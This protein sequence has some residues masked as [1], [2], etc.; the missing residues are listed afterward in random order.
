MPTVSAVLSKF[1]RNDPPSGTDGVPLVEK[2]M[3]V[4]TATFSVSPNV[5]TNP[6]LVRVPVGLASASQLP[7]SVPEVLAATE[8]CVVL[9]P[10]LGAIVNRYGTATASASGAKAARATRAAMTARDAFPIRR[11]DVG[12]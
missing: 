1:M 2:L 5:P 7:M 9:R 8:A 3:E 6:G 11:A 10:L 4:L 12:E